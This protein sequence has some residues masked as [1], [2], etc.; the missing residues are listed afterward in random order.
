[1]KPI[2]VGN[3]EI[4]SENPVYI[5]A[6]IG[7]NHNGDLET[8]KKMVQSA[9][10]LGA[11]AVKFQTFTAQNIMTKSAGAAAHLEVGSGKEDV[12]S[13]VQR[14]SLS[15]DDHRDLYSA[16]QDLGISF[17]STPFGTDSVDLL[18]EL[19]VSAYKVASMDLD[20][21]P[22]LEYI[23]GKGK[24]IFMSTGMG[25]LGEVERALN[26]IY[27]TGNNQVVVLHCTSLYPPPA[28]GINL[29]AMNTM[30]SAFDVPVGYSDH[31][32]GVAVPLAAVALGACVIE[33]HFTLDKNMTGPDHA[34]SC[35]PP[36]FQRLVSEIRDIEKALGSPV[37]KPVREE[38]DM[39]CNFRR[40]IV[41]AVNIP[42]GAAIERDM[43][44][45]KR[46]GSGISPMN[47]Q[48]VIGRTTNK[49]IP[50][51]TVIEKNDLS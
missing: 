45:F 1:M 44:T 9:W 43:V 10:E 27:S 6:E 50:V 11:D 40:S 37:K 24:P 5:I 41:A 25:L 26:T 3:R 14:I 17:L 48:W 51:D 49:P 21:L 20:N 35:D 13:F 16:C 7:I 23:A 36:E 42:D 33:K 2:S 47:L 18:E 38:W 22:L 39:R 30:R 28:D 4:G 32:V 29:L 12:Y 34:V 46:P 19:G 8:A 15:P 31:T